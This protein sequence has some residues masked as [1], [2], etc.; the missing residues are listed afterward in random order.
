MLGLQIVLH[1]ARLVFT[2][3]GAALRIG[4]L[5]V[6]IALVASALVMVI[7]GRSAWQIMSAGYAAQMAQSGAFLMVLVLALIWLAVM[8]WIFVNWHRFVLLAEY[9]QSWVPPLP[10]EAMGLYLGRSMQLFGISVLI[11][12]VLALIL[13]VTGLGATALGSMA[14]SIAV[15]YLFYRVCAA[16]PAAAI[17]RPIGLGAAWR[18]TGRGAG[19]VA[20]VAG[21]MALLQFLSTVIPAQ[22]APASLYLA[23]VIQVLFSVLMAMVQVSVVTTIYGHFVEDRPVG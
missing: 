4:L 10:K 7:S 13:I 5:P 18:V 22:I 21:L 11:G 3:L 16:L 14:M 1:A 8:L 19:T 17:Q 15:G 12:I 6:I 2:N 23:A 9:P 20:I